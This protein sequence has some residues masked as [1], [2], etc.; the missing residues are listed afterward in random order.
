MELP[1]FVELA[2]EHL[3]LVK[4]EAQLVELTAEYSISAVELELDLTL[5][6]LASLQLEVLKS[7]PPTELAE[8]AVEMAMVH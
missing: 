3:L 5:S 8:A 4:F 6:Q 7:V 1:G 2:Q